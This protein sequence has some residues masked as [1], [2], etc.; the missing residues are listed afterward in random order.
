V[1]KLLKKAKTSYYSEKIAD[2]D[3]DTKK[4]Y[5]VT[6]HLL[7]GDTE[8]VFPD[9]S[10]DKQLAEDF[11]HFFLNTIN[12]IRNDLTSKTIH[13]AVLPQTAP[14]AVEPLVKFEPT[15]MKEVA[16]I[17][18]KAPEKSCEL[19]PVPTWLLKEC[20][21]DLLPL[22]TKIINH[23]M[24]L[25]H[26]PNSFKVAHVRPLIK[27]PGLDENN[28][29]NYRP[30]SNLPFLSKVLERVVDAR[31]NKHMTKHK[32]QE[33]M[34]SAYR[35]LHSTET[36][37]LKVQSDILQSLDQ[38]NASILILLDLSSAFDTI[39]H[40]ILLERLKDDF[41]VNGRSLA[42][43]TSYLEDR[44]QTVCVRNASS[45]SLPLQHG[46]P[47]GSVLGPKMFVMYT[48]PVGR[49]FQHH[50]LSY[51]FYADDT[52]LYVSFKSKNST[53]LEESIKRLERCL[54]DVETWMCNSLLKLNRDKTEMIFLAPKNAL[55]EN[56]SMLIGNTVITS[57]SSVRNLGV[58]FDSTLNMNQHISLTCKAAYLQ[59]KTHRLH[60]EVPDRHCMQVTSKWIGHISCGY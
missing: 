30:V 41:A 49:I 50:G 56:V 24:E 53:T 60:Q 26:V 48:K 6:K 21:N 43:I 3:R 12:T 2:A 14:C 42:W 27:K 45:S 18:T 19:D 20:L 31:I 36:A 54:I 33:D 13:N 55:P 44:Y 1:N 34:Q 46:V 17:I 22:I 10:S 40:Q 51:H 37:L 39:D 28:L 47:Q 58:T 23:S 32:L 52:Q 7:D 8:P 15:T 59:L 29:K 9:S 35:K 5:K 25:G 38:G 11:G 16:D 4:M 57:T